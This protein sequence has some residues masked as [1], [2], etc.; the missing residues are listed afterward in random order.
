MEV[1]TITTIPIIL[2][3]FTICFPYHYQLPPA[4]SGRLFLFKGWTGVKCS[5]ISCA[6][7]KKVR[8]VVT[9]VLSKDSLPNWYFVSF[10]TV[11]TSICWMQHLS[12]LHHIVVWL[13]IN[14]TTTWL[15]RTTHSPTQWLY[16]RYIISKIVN[17][18][19]S[20]FV[21]I[22]SLHQYQFKGIF[23]VLLFSFALLPDRGWNNFLVFVCRTPISQSGWARNEARLLLQP[24]QCTVWHDC[25]G[26]G[27]G[28]DGEPKSTSN[29]TD[30]KQMWTENKHKHDYFSYKL[31][32]RTS[33]SVPKQNKTKSFLNFSSTSYWHTTKSRTSL[34]TFT[35]GPDFPTGSC[36]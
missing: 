23:Y 8:Q 5:T 25:N 3:Y 11:C 1:T 15:G 19:I 13:Y 30:G 27:S 24:P 28:S 16:I 14:S 21:N 32:C 7:N 9:N 6:T 10:G 26:T 31:L 18:I 34:P 36:S 4:G 22:T 33:V 17:I 29:C 35:T 20:K 2:L 12:S